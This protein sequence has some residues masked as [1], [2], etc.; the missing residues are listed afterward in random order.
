MNK[1]MLLLGAS[2]FVLILFSVDTYAAGVSVTDEKKLSEIITNSEDLSGQ[3]STTGGAIAVVKD[4][5]V[6]SI[7]NGSVISNNKVTRDDNNGGAIL[8]Q[9]TGKVKDFNNVTFSNNSTDS[10]NTKG[11]AIAVNDTTS[12]LGLITDSLFEGNNSIAGG[13]IYN[14]GT[15]AGITGTSGTGENK[16]AN[17]NSN[18]ANQGGAIYNHATISKITNSN[19]EG[20]TAE[21]LG[22]AI[23]NS[24]FYG[25]TDGGKIEKISDSIFL[26]NKSVSED[27]GTGGGAIYNNG[28]QI[29]EISSTDF[30][31]NSSNNDGGAIYTQSASNTTSTGTTTGNA[32]I[33]IKD[34]NFEENSALK[35][36]GAIFIKV[37]SENE[38]LVSVLDI[39]NTTFKNNT[40]KEGGAI[41][42]DAKSKITLTN[43]TFED[44]KTLDDW[45]NGK[46]GAIYNNGEITKLSANFTNNTT[47]IEGAGGAIYNTGTISEL[48][49]D[50]TDNSAG[51]SVREDTG[52]YGGAIYNAG[53]IGNIK[54]NFTNNHVFS[55]AGG[56]GAI[57]N[58][59]TIGDILGNFSNNIARFGG[60]IY[61]TGTIGAISGKFTNNHGFGFI[62]TSYIPE[63]LGG[64]IYSIK[65]ISLLAK[66]NSTTEFTGN[67]VKNID[68][69]T[70]NAIYMDAADATLKMQALTNGK[71]LFNDEIDGKSGY[72]ISIEGDATGSVDFNNNI[73]NADIS[74][75]DTVVNL[76]KAAYLDNNNKLTINSGKFNVTSL[77]ADDVLKANSITINGGIL[78]IASVDVDL[79]NTKMGRI[80]GSILTVNDTGKI[81]IDKMLLIS[82]ASNVITNVDFIT[83]GSNANVTY[84]DT[85]LQKVLAPVY[86]YN[87][88]YNNGQFT[89]TR[90]DLN[91][92]AG[93]NTS[94]NGGSGSGS[95]TGGTGGDN[96]GNEDGDNGN[97]RPTNPDYFNPGVFTGDIFALS[98]LDMQEN[99]VKQV[100]DKPIYFD[101]AKGR[102]WATPYYTDETVGYSGFYDVDS[103]NHGVIAGVDTKAFGDAAGWTSVYT[104]F[105]AYNDGEYKYEG[106]K[107]ENKSLLFG[108]KASI[109][110]GGFYGDAVLD[111]ASHDM[112][113]WTAF[114]KDLNDTFGYGAA[115][116]AG[117]KTTVDKL[118]IDTSATLSWQKVKGDDYTSRSTAR[119][120]TE[121]YS[122]VTV[123]P[124]VKLGYNLDNVKPYVLAR[125]NVV[126]NEDGS[127]YA[128]DVKLPT[129]DSKDYVEYGVGVETTKSDKVSGYAHFLRRDGGREGWN[130]T[131]GIKYNF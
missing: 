36:G 126:L 30:V 103:R 21:L 44:N 7:D 116:K 35:K 57:I 86:K 77:G 11:G 111:Y 61:N 118:D 107:V 22:G 112:R 101:Y 12:S 59:G 52:S 34:S 43:V 1:N 29:A 109:Y 76:S 128:N 31:Q 3:S 113:A 98:G 20:N 84:A 105:A 127:S 45:L 100:L 124:Q 79:E 18:T 82:E 63:P 40:A 65:D 39:E 9:G 13:A 75:K 70:P 87:V 125:Y 42:A 92:P 28:G 117:Y 95:G 4:G 32:K 10:S 51:L 67:Y 122:R 88:T 38:N 80:D 78:N 106:V 54:S 62:E 5:G 23:L 41:Y 27:T 130:F 108:L 24:A 58:N 19:F 121:D 72:K 102:V 120:S 15:M 99:T 17:F 2:V 64:A 6:L 60:A 8:I 69:I 74:L 46:G 26:G 89:F 73:K 85:T 66:D 114:G 14:K 56:G 123:S 119:I 48:S 97:T 53:T 49:G 129:F 33:L 25:A 83:G 115:L 94:G 104:L 93:G 91:P 50:F 96:S 110:N 68:V 131:A 55:S 71:I 37:D 90:A 81:N 16:K 47:S